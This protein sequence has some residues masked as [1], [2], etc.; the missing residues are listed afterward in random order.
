MS[1]GSLHT[2][3]RDLCEQLSHAGQAG[4]PDAALL[5][6]WISHR[7]EA[8]FELLIRRHGAMVLG[9]CRRVLHHPQDVEDAFQATFLLL[10]RKVAGIRQRNTLGAW[11]HK[12]ALRVALRA[13]ATRSRLPERVVEDVEAPQE[14]DDLL[15]RDLRPVLD[16]EIN[17]LP[18]RYRLPFVLC[19]LEGKTNQEAADALGCPVGTI[20]SR[21]HWARGRLRNRL[22]RR[23][24]T[25]SLTLLAVLLERQMALAAVPA[26]L[27]ESCC[28]GVLSS[29]STRAAS[30]AEGVLRSMFLIKL[31]WSM[32]ILVVCGLSLTAWKASESANA[33]P[34]PPRHHKKDAPRRPPNMETPAETP[35]DWIVVSTNY[36]GRL[37]LIAREIH[38]GEKVP[39]ERIATTT[40]DKTK[41]YYRLQEGDRVEKDDL[42]G[43]T[44]DR[45]ARAEADI[46]KA[47]IVAA[48]SER[49]S[50]EKTRDEAKIRY[51]RTVKLF[52]EGGVGVDDLSGAKLAWECYVEEVKGK[53]ANLEI[54]RRELDQANLVVQL[55]EIRSPVA[56]TIVSILKKQGEAV[57]ELEGVFRIKVEEK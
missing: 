33:A 26:P 57:K 25:V 32:A 17:H 3:V 49:Q 11:L 2:F 39:E 40:E 55:H 37:S 31:K 53:M 8:A 51:E 1:R 19:N 27:I 18:D 38:P 42:L 4:M 15:W 44:D 5:E 41:R 10:L 43:R 21:L 16:E 54:A 34:A 36:P 56:G 24:V 45:L 35:R 48:E 30:L 12:V 46:K 20:L 29:F 28:L 9:V 6:R 52:R 7:D 23:G 22:Q 13:R 14:K 50:S 47:K